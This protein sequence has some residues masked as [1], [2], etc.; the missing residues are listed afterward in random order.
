MLSC[1]VGAEDKCNAA[2]C[3]KLGC[4]PAP[5][6]PKA[7]RPFFHLIRVC[8]LQDIITRSAFWKMLELSL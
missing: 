3:S 2:Q 8:F 1:C 4:S 7:V 5:V 6:V